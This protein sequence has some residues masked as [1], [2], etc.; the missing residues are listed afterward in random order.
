MLASGMLADWFL[1][2]VY[3]ITLSGMRDAV[4][5]W[6]F[7]GASLSLHQ[8]AASIDASGSVQRAL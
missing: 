5:A 1:P 8:I 3:N 7:V 6:I 4:P 2:F